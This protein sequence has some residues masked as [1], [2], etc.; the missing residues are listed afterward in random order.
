MMSWKQEY[1]RKN[2]GIDPLA[3]VL[4]VVLPYVVIFVERNILHNAFY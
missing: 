1:H 2:I 4:P 3:A